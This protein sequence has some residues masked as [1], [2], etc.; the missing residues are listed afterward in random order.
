MNSSKFETMHESRKKKARAKMIT[1]SPYYIYRSRRK[2]PEYCGSKGNETKD[3]GSSIGSYAGLESVISTR[4]HSSKRSNTPVTQ[5][6]NT[7]RGNS[8]SIRSSFRDGGLGSLGKHRSNNKGKNEVKVHRQFRENSKKIDGM[9]GNYGLTRPKS[10]LYTQRER[11]KSNNENHGDIS[12]IAKFFEEFH[13]KS[14]LLLS[15]FEKQIFKNKDK[16]M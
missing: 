14:K 13:E 1:I 8:F 4:D 16:P 9:I 7:R 2:S 11:K 15:K 6:L 3:T 5:S 12:E 10:S